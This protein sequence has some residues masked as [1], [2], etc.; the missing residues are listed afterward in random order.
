MCGSVSNT[1]AGASGSCATERGVVW[2]EG[3]GAYE[4]D[5][6][7][8]LARTT[9]RPVGAR[10]TSLPLLRQRRKTRRPRRYGRHN[11]MIPDA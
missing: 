6:K 1:L 4:R 5:I 3:V 10:K 9:A 11:A 2:N 8:D 7:A